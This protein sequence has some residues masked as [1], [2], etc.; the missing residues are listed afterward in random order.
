MANSLII[1][2]DELIDDL[3][4]D[5]YSVIVNGE[6]RT[7]QSTDVEGLYSTYIETNDVVT[8]SI[9][10]SPSGLLRVID[11]IRRDY[12]T[13]DI[14]GDNGIRDTFISSSSGTTGTTYVTTFTAT[15]VAICYNYEYRITITTQEN[16]RCEIVGTALGTPILPPILKDDLIIYANGYSFTGTTG[17]TSLFWLDSRGNFNGSC[18]PTNSPTPVVWKTFNSGFFELN[19]NIIAF[20]RVTA[21]NPY[22]V[23]SSGYTYT[24]G[25]WIQ[26]SQSSNLHNFYGAGTFFLYKNT[27]NYLEAKVDQHLGST[28]Y[29]TSPN[30]LNPNSNIWNYVLCKWTP[31]D[32]LKL[33]LNGVLVATT[34]TPFSRMGQTGVWQIGNA[35]GT[36]VSD[37]QVYYRG[38]S[39]AEVLFN[40]NQLKSFYGY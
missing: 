24:I 2:F 10:T 26:T 25:G 4:V 14:S 1:T 19:G 5:S 27:S 7:N 33:Y 35:S 31:N 37:F 34:S 12:T 29:A 28:F 22:T 39:D 21:S 23:P 6:Q 20:P 32:S 30:V 40:F 18:P 17:G 9:E 38:L 11:I 8:I 16:P 15:T 36:N 3:G 13:D